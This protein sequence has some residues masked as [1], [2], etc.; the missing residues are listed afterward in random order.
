MNHTWK[1]ARRRL[2]QITA[3]TIFLGLLIGASGTVFTVFS[4]VL[5]HLGSG[6]A[7][8]FTSQAANDT[9]AVAGQT[10]LNSFATDNGSDIANSVANSPT[11]GTTN[12]I[13]GY[14]PPIMEYTNPSTPSATQVTSNSTQP[15]PQ[16][17]AP[18]ALASAM[19]TGGVF[20]GERIS[21]VFGSMLKGVLNTLFINTN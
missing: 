17:A 19:D 20:V 7:A 3:T 4:S 9:T 21:H 16:D 8:T 11:S 18:S 12:S 14:Q 5:S 13:S 1:H 15:D 10:S 2:K 6:Q